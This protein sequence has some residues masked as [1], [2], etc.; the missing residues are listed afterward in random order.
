MNCKIRIPE[1]LID[2]KNTVN[3]Y[4][5]NAS[6][7][8]PSLSHTSTP[9]TSGTVPETDKKLSENPRTVRTKRARTHSNNHLDMDVHLP[10]TFITTFRLV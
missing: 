2:I 9:G 1:I 3:S 7:R 5:N 10:T 6:Y 4:R 8:L